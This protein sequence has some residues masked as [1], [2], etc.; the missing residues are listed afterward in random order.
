M[1]IRVFCSL[2]RARYLRFLSTALQQSSWSGLEE[3][4]VVIEI[5]DNTK[6]ARR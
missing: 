2:C 3:L 1:R 4:L 5:K 6:H